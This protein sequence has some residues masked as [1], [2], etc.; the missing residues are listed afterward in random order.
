MPSAVL[1]NCFE[2]ATEDEDELCVLAVGRGRTAR[3]HRLRLQRG[4]A[5]EALRG[6][7]RAGGDGR[8]VRQDARDQAAGM[9]FR[10]NGHS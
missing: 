8:R 5:H 2:V 9:S 4:H 10:P 3:Q 6:D 7:G 1:I